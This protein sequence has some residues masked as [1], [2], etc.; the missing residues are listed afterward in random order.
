MKIINRPNYTLLIGDDSVELFD[1][2]GVDTLHGLTRE[3]AELYGDTNDDAYIAGMSN[4]HPF[5][6]GLTKFPKPYT[7]I[8]KKRLK[9]DYRDVTLLMH[10]LMHQS[11]LQHNYNIDLE[12]MI[13]S[14]ANDEADYLLKHSIIP[15]YQVPGVLTK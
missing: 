4:Y 15:T 13:I 5:D 11:F 12:E 14:W 10:E 7:F 6:K 3:V 8:N 1:F 2:F 9:N